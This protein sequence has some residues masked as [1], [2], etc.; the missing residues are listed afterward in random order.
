MLQPDHRQRLLEVLR[1]EYVDEAKD[2][3]QFEEHARRMTYPHFRE[4]LL[5]IAEEEKAHVKWLRDKIQALGGEIPQMTFTVK[6]GRNSWENL[7]MDV[8]EEKRDH[9]VVLEQLYTAVEHAD[10]EIAEGLHRI[11]EDEKRHREEILDLLLRSDPYALP[12]PTAEQAQLERQKQAWLEQQKMAWLD[13]RRAEW[14]A[15][16]KQTP[17][18]EWIAEREFEWAVNQLPNLELEWTRLLVKQEIGSGA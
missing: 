10:P 1:D 5:R 12:R 13:K 15:A 18:A 16:G 14:E 2:V 9:T 7:L 3:V 6:N 17:W 4:R 8:E 11:R